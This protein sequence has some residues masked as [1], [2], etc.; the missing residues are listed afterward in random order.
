MKK[1]TLP[2]PPEAR[3]VTLSV[4]IKKSTSEALAK[5]A[6]TNSRTKSALAETVL[7]AWLRQEGFLR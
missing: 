2:P 4:K 5:A 3:T 1:P 6:K 7:E